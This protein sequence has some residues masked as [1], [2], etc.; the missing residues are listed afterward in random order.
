MAKRH[1][2]LIR[3]DREVLL[4]EHVLSSENEILNIF[5]CYL[6]AHSVSRLVAPCMSALWIMH[7]VDN[8]TNYTYAYTYAMMSECLWFPSGVAPFD[9]AFL[10]TDKEI[11]ALSERKKCLANLGSFQRG[12]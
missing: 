3:L 9:Q 2:E 12:D 11:L 8:Y 5:L 6:S 10:Q 7:D 1:G 4:D